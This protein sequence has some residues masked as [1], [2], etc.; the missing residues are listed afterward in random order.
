[1]IQTKSAV[2]WLLKASV[3]AGLLFYLAKAAD[4][5]RI[6]TLDKT[7]YMVLGISVL[8]AL[9]LYLFMALRWSI[10]VRMQSTLPFSLQTAY[11]GYLMG[12]FFSIFMPGIIGS[13]LVR[14]KYCKDRCDFNYKTSSLIVIIERLFG[15]T[16][17]SLIFM[18]GLLNNYQLLPH[19]QWDLNWVIL[20]ESIILI[21]I[22]LAKYWISRRI[23]IKIRKFMTLIF[24][25]FMGQLT[26]IINVGLLTWSFGYSVSISQFFFIMPIVYIATALPISLGGLGVREGILA[27]MLAIYGVVSTDAIIIAFMSYLIKVFIGLTLGLPIF[28]KVRTILSQLDNQNSEK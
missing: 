1:M 18:I 11:R 23:H 15:L 19:L 5:H 9:F 16:A 17:L 12:F 8:I 24:L 20:A 4:W 27:S 3:S 25:S 10:L 14:I 22:T 6:T 13:D 28:L 7:S 21:I 2:L 26:D